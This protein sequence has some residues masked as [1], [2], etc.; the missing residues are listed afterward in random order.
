[1]DND[2]IQTINCA[3]CNANVPKDT[4]FCTE[5][6]KTME[7]AITVETFKNNTSCPQCNSEVEDGLKFC[8]ECGTKIEQISTSVQVTTCPKC[9]IEVEPGL[10][11][12]TECGE[13]IGHTSANHA[14]CPKC[15]A[16]TQPGLRFCTECGTSLEIKNE[17]KKDISEELKKLRKSHGKS[18]APKDETVES[19]VKSG[20]GL[21][22]GLGG[23]LDK[24]ATE[25][26]KNI[27]QASKKGQGT[28]NYEISQK[29]KE[30]REKTK[31]KPGYL[32]CNSCGGY[33][34][35]QPGEAPD[36]FSD[37]CDCGGRFKHQKNLT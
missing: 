13:K 5:C 27:N 33:Y 25:I 1:M 14:T 23:F 10:R 16:E 37:E 20:K 12:C 7:Q 28:Q 4:K 9:F 8:T 35:L 18:I 22:K 32:V 36:D 6:G 19:V 26:D 34:E 11:F 30:H 21:M 29:L 3:N 2:L 15:F 31:T 17:S 24:T